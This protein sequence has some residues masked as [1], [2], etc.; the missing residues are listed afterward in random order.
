MYFVR[1]H[2]GL[3]GAKANFE[4]P[5][6]NSRFDFVISDMWNVVE[7]MNDL[8]RIVESVFQIVVPPMKVELADLYSTKE[9]TYSHSAEVNY[10]TT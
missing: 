5:K 1:A 4:Y 10:G 9:R 6:F 7:S 3:I 8:R 2:A